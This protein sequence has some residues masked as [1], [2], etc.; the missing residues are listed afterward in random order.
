M[1]VIQ[2]N[3]VCGVGSTGRIATDI[4]KTLM[5]KKHESYIAYGRGN[6]RDCDHGI[7]VGNNWGIYSHVLRTRL[8]DH[9][10]F[11]SV[12]AT[13]RLIK[14]LADMN[15]DVIHLHNIHGYYLNIE[16]LFNYLKTWNKPVIW[17]LHDCW[18][19]TGHCAY[20]TYAKCSKWK[21][22]CHDCPEKNA[23][24]SS[25]VMDASKSNY[26]RKQEIFRGVGHLTIVTPSNWLAELVKASFLKNYPVRVINNGIDLSVFYPQESDFRKKHHLSQKYILLGVASVWDRRKGL[27]YFR[28]LSEQLEEDEAIV[29]V[30]LTKEQVSSLP[31]RVI[32]IT[33]TNNVKELAEIYSSADVFVN[34]T[35][36]DNFPTTN[37]EAI[38]C[39][40][41]V[42]TFATGGSPESINEATGI[43][44][45]QKD[46]HGIREAIN[47][48][49][50]KEQG[51][52]GACVKRARNLYDKNDRYREYIGLYEEMRTKR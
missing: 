47:A 40:T 18:P 8:F 11:G 33:R 27:K 14:E 15:P 51:L 21:T 32:G 30:G 34:P 38:A 16:V 10:G 29:L 5:E 13:K 12:K 9:H 17:T 52:K 25:A 36:E 28:Q 39:G 41:P 48:I 6:A 26:K 7:K 24:P 42:I 22:G 49:R 46:V 37:L 35:L 44:V 3:S 19:F 50:A 4:H 23:Y 1:K 2:V 45:T 31:D 43:S 20:F